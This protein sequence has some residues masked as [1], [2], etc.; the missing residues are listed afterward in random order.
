MRATISFM[1]C[2]SWFCLR[3]PKRAVPRASQ[4][5]ARFDGQM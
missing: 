3:T 4:I 5:V 1:S 2:D